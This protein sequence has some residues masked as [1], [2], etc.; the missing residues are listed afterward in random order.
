MISFTLEKCGD[1][2]ERA[3]AAA[4]VVRSNL[5]AEPASSAAKLVRGN[6]PVDWIVAAHCRRA[7]PINDGRSTI[8]GFA[9]VG[10][11]ATHR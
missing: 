10:R 8:H 3:I 6:E 7:V 5:L 2:L 11:R 9:S 1:L 4:L